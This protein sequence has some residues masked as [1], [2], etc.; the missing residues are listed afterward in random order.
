M[1]SKDHRSA[2]KTDPEYLRSFGRRRGKK[3]RP[4][5]ERLMADALP[6]LTFNL[7]LS[8][9][10]QFERPFKAYWLEVGF[11]GGEHLA[12]QASA[13]PDIGL[14]GCEPFMDG[15]AKAVTQ[16]NETGLDNVRLHADDARQTFPQIPDGALDRVFV[17]FPDPWPKARHNKR[18]LIQGPLLDDI[19]RM[20][21]DGG[22][23]RFASD[24][25]DYVRWVLAHVM[26]HPEFEWTAQGPA[27][28][29]TPPD[30]WIRTRYEQKALARGEKCVYLRFRRRPRT[31]DKPTRG[32]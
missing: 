11:G 21:R 14:V 12:A 1:T 25:M 31:A 6:A 10:E 17:L 8:L 28:W 30:D 4:G 3:L 2:D 29:R 24:H 5:R 23:F 20:L 18:R 19:A 13:N 15:V 27:D 32:I 16:I 9:T 7:N 22:E 26:R